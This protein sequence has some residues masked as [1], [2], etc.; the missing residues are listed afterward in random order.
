MFLIKVVDNNI[1]SIEYKKAFFGFSAN[2]RVI[3]QFASKILK[4]KR[5]KKAVK[6]LIWP[7]LMKQ[8]KFSQK[9]LSTRWS[10]FDG[11][12]PYKGENLKK[13]KLLVSSCPP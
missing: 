8:K 7:L 5:S 13:V 3:A 11:F 6:R 1:L 9:K 10:N 2:I 12:Q 4:V